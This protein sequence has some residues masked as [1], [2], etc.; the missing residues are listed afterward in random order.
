MRHDSPEGRKTVFAPDALARARSR[1][2]DQ[3]LSVKEWS[4]RHGFPHAQVR[5]ILVG[6]RPCHYGKAHRIAVA[7]GLKRDPDAIALPAT[8]EG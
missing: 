3:G 8:A 6:T 7:L 2:S 5:N 1:I 4:E